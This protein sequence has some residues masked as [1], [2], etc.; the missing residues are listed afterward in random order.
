MENITDLV[1]NVAAKNQRIETFAA[2]VIEINKEQASLHNP[3]DAYTVNIMRGDGAILKN[4]RLKASIQDLEH[5]IITI[6]KKDSW[7]LATIIDGVETRAFISQYAEVDRVM[8]RI[9][10]T[11]DPKL[12]FDY[13]ADGTKLHIRYMKTDTEGESNEAKITDVAKIEFDKDQNFKISYF[14]A[15]EKPLAV[16]HFSPD[17]LTATFNSV[18]DNVVTEGSVLKIT[19]NTTDLKINDDKGK[20]RTSLLLKPSNISARLF[21]EDEKE[22]LTFELSGNEKAEIKLTD[23]NDTILLEKD[24]IQLKKD[25]NNLIELLGQNGVNI[26]TSGNINL[27]GANINIDAST[28]I[29]I[30]A[31]SEIIVEAAKD[32]TIKGD[33]VLIN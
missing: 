9:Q 30:K 32:T 25:P 29:S 16:T 7:V 20:K 33:N 4:V 26:L 24:K 19:K 8:G 5:G 18:K 27:K 22:K 23:S 28:N 14:D 15:D 3:E 21:N 17:S 31:N 1:K 10:A 13:S 12:F 11:S 6:P 2:R